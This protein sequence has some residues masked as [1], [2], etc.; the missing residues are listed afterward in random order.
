M[1]GEAQS[2]PYLLTLVPFYQTENIDGSALYAGSSWSSS[3]CHATFL[4]Q[5]LLHSFI[6][7]PIHHQIKLACKN[8]VRGQWSNA[9]VLWCLYSLQIL[10]IEP[11]NPPSRELVCVAS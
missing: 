6:V 11:G 10:C 5:I 1:V 8:T 4:Q 9:V 2:I 3:R 7:Q